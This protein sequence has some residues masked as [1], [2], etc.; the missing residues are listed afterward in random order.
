MHVICRSAIIRHPAVTSAKNVTVLVSNDDQ[1]ESVVSHSDRGIVAAVD[2]TG[3][4]DKQRH[5]H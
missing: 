1:D 5:H 4:C 2:V 3:G